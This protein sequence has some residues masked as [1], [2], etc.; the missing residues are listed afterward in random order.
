MDWGYFKRNGHSVYVII[1][2][3]RIDNRVRLPKAFFGLS[4]LTNHQ[5]RYAQDQHSGQHEIHDQA[6]LAF[7]PVHDAT[8]KAEIDFFHL[9]NGVFLNKHSKVVYL[10]VAQ[11]LLY[12]AFEEKTV[13]PPMTLEMISHS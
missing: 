11:R 8:L 2:V 10:V 3:G 1:P 6:L 9:A 13:R 4:P 12:Q 7:L 5:A